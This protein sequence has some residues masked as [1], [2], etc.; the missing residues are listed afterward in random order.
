MLN[1]EEVKEFLRRKSGYQKE[2]AY[3]LAKKLNADVNVCGQALREI[4]KE[5]FQPS[6]NLNRPVKRLFFDIETSFNIGWFWRAGYN[7][8][9][10]PDQIIHEKAIISISWKWEGEDKVYSKSWNNGCD[11]ELVETIIKLLNESDEIVGHN[12][13]RFDT[14]Y[15]LSRALFHGIPAL[16]IYKTFDTLKKAKYHFNFNSNKLDY[17]AKLLGLGGKYQHSGLQMWKDIVYYDVLKMG[18]KESRDKA[19][20]EMITYNEMDVILT[21]EVFNRL[22]LYTRQEVHHGVL[23]GK[24]KFTCPNDGSEN[25]EFVKTI[26]TSAGTI[27][28]IMQCNDCGQQFVISNKDYLKYLKQ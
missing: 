25:V 21:E 12:L 6:I 10:T 20:K 27:K 24:P 9:V 23:M 1:K 28:H 7:Q 13:E 2:G 22:R 8:T 14:P 17:L 19:L 16:P 26:V 3:R 18:S 15:I 11:K 5:C 4:R